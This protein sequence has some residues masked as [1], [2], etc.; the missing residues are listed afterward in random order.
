MPLFEPLTLGGLVLP[1]RIVMAPLDRALGAPA[2]R[3]PTDLVAQYYVQRAGA[4][5]TISEATHVSA[6]TVSRRG[7]TAIHAEDQV[8]AWRKIIDVVHETGGR[9]V[10]QLFHLGRK[11]DPALRPLEAAA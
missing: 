7:A 8:T 6:D 5:L 10:Q 11:A 2:S 9:I 3:E 1:N 4:G